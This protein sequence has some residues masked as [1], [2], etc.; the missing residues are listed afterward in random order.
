MHRKQVTWF[1]IKK[2]AFPFFI[3]YRACIASK[4]SR[5]CLPHLHYLL[6]SGQNN[7]DDKPFGSQSEGIILQ[8]GRSLP[9]L[10]RLMQYAEKDICNFSPV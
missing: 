10:T 9:I 7:Q 3:Y 6:F 1:I 8:K 5:L 4:A 2:I